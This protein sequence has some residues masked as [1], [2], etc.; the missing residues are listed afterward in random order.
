MIGPKIM[1]NMTIKQIH[2]S[3]NSI[4][5]EIL[6]D[7]I[8]DGHFD[9]HGKSIENEHKICSVV[10]HSIPKHLKERKKIVLRKPEFLC[11]P[12]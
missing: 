7:N 12:K 4:V 10:L 8:V 2:F 11:A 6:R 9:S 3:N 5:E 1:L